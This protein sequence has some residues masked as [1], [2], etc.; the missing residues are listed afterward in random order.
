MINNR[1]TPTEA[2]PAPKDPLS[3]QDLMLYSFAAGTLVGFVS[4]LL[5]VAL[6]SHNY[7]KNVYKQLNRHWH[8][9]CVDRGYAEYVVTNETLVWRWIPLASTNKV[10]TP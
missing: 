5:A 1:P 9:A 6:Y 10:T 3:T 2:K 8:E 4:T 7:E